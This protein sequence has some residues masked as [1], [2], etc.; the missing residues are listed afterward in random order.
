MSTQVLVDGD[1]LSFAVPATVTFIPPVTSSISVISGDNLTADGKAAVVA[2]DIAPIVIAGISY[3]T[4]SHTIPGSGIITI[5]VP[6]DSLS[7]VLTK[8]VLSVCL[9]DGGGTYLFTVIVPAMIPGVPPIPDPVLVKT[10]SFS[11]TPSQS[12][13]TG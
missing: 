1:T 6:W 3:T 9:S 2:T 5:V 13:L 4:V 10:G 7:S 12:V 8:N 11:A